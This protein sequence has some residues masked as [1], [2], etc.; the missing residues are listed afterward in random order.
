[1]TQSITIFLD[2]FVLWDGCRLS[3]LLTI[4][5]TKLAN[6]FSED[7]KILPKGW[8]RGVVPS[9]VPIPQAWMARRIPGQPPPRISKHYGVK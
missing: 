5:A 7:G 2:F 6:P 3:E 4:R 9:A 1:L 8:L